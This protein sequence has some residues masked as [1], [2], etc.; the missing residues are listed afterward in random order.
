M[1][2][3]EPLR[4]GGSQSDYSFAV[5]RGMVVAQSLSSTPFTHGVLMKSAPI[6][7]N[8]AARMA[9]VQAANILNTPREER[10]DRLTDFGQGDFRRQYGLD[11]NCG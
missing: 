8:E 5:A 2:I 10:F 4:A 1:E 7:D 3:G 11:H 9:D 6:P